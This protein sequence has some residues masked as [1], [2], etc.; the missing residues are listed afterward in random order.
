M[1]GIELNKIAASILLASLIAMVVGVI[2]NVLYKP[3]LQLAKRGYQIEVTESNEPSAGTDGT[4]ELK[5]DIAALMTKANADAG[6]EVVKK[7]LSCH[8]F[9]NGGAN[10][11]G[12]N[13]W[14]VPG[15]PKAHRKDF[16]YSKALETKGGTW[17]DDSLF[18][19][20]H[21]PS[22][23]LPG[24]KMS[25]AGLSKPEDVANVIAFLKQKAS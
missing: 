3:K 7:C 16:A 22:K 11:V 25:F 18:H 10:K 21:K 4:E 19:F 6:A 14:A 15:G 23:F 12:P 1:S 13:L 9:D 17:D 5:I 2:A 8:S 24:T 20:L